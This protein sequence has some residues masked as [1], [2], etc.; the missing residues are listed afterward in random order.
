MRFLDFSRIK[1][2]A[3]ETQ[4]WTVSPLPRED[5]KG[6]WTGECR[7]RIKELR[8]DGCI[9]LSLHAMSNREDYHH[10]GGMNS[11]VRL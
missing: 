3:R 10:L 9:S 1:F 4:T 2:T 8:V 11:L 6:I 7:E 5:S